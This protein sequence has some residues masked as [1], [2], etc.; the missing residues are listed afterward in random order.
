LEIGEGV[1]ASVSGR[2]GSPGSL[3]VTVRERL[4]NDPVSEVRVEIT[5]PSG[6]TTTTDAHGQARFPG[7]SPGRYLVQLWQDEFEMSPETVVTSVGDGEEEDLDITINRVI[8][9]VTIKMIHPHGRMRALV[10][11]KSD[12]EYGHWWVE[13][14]GVESYGWWPSRAVGPIDTVTGMPGRLNRM[15]RAFSG[16][17][18]RDMHHGDNA[19]EKFHP[20]VNSG[21]NAVQVK[22]EM[23]SF[24]KA[25]SG[26]WSYPFGQNCHSFQES[27]M[28]HCHLNKFGSKKVE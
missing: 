5:G 22:N 8:M 24:A 2:N 12:L 7:R 27:M 10:G 4:S 21:Q 16:S 18:T 14:D 20:A 13:L 19:E 3:V 9:T 6:G 15:D 11:D 25:Y 17:P 26:S 23:R 28:D 1:D